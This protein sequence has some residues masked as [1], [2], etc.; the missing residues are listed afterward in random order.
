MAGTGLPSLLLGSALA[1]V[2]IGGPGWVAV[3]LVIAA[4]LFAL[5]DVHWLGG[6]W[7]RES[8]DER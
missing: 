1:V 5:R 7:D 4:L 3:A 8:D 2:L 6:G